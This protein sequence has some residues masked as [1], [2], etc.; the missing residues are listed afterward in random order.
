MVVIV[1]KT[2][3]ALVSVYRDMVIEGVFVSDYNG[4][5]PARQLG[6]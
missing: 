6:C 3:T 2:E 5:L 4:E 1:A